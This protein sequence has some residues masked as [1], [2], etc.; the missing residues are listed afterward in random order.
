MTTLTN[1]SAAGLGQRPR[2]TEGFLDGL[3]ARY[4]QYRVYRRT[5]EE[6]EALTD[7]DLADLG[8]S[9]HDVADVARAA[10]YGK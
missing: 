6:L 7:R 3:R 9:R 5:L 4:A 2:R 1:I 8:I 10:A